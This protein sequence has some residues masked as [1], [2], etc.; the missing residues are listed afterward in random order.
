MALHIC[1]HYCID[2]MIKFIA[3]AIGTVALAAAA[4][5]AIFMAIFLFSL[6]WHDPPSDAEMMARFRQEREVFTRLLAL[7]D[8]PDD[9]GEVRALIARIGA[10]HRA[11]GDPGV[12][13]VYDASWYAGSGWAK[14]YAYVPRADLSWTVVPDLDAG[15]QAMDRNTPWRAERLLDGGWVLR[16]DYAP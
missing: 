4:W 6:G 16:L 12:T 8:R 10:S 1:N 15:F 13:V 5:V 3:Y 9:D 14:M 11:Y 7:R 2:R